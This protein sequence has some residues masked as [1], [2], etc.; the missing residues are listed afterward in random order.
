[1]HALQIVLW[2]MVWC[3]A[4]AGLMLRAHRNLSVLPKA[5]VVNQARRWAGPLQLPSHPKRPV[6]SPPVAL[7]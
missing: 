6:P 1:M 5:A 2:P 3:Q 7:Q 4:D